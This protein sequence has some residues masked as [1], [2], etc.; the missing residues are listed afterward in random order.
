[1]DFEYEWL[2]NL[3]NFKVLLNNEYLD[4]IDD[5]EEDIVL[6]NVRW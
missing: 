4:D 3:F 2:I 5:D 1:M 6:E